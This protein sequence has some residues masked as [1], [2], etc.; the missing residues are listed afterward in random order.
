MKLGKLNKKERCCGCGV[1]E[2]SADGMEMQ[3]DW[4]ACKSFHIPTCTLLMRLAGKRRD[5]TQVGQRCYHMIKKRNF[6][7]MLITVQQWG[8]DLVGG[9]LQSM[10]KIWLQNTECIFKQ[11]AE[12]DEK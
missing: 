1:Q 8:P 6:L 9:S 7:I 12:R 3:Q 10:R 5:K 4:I 2:G 11:V